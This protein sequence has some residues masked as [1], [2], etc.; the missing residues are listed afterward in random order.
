D[1][2]DPAGGGGPDSPGHRA[3]PGERAAAAPA[4]VGRLPCRPRG[5]LLRRALVG[6]GHG[7]HGTLLLS[8]PE[9]SAKGAAETFADASGSDRSAL[10]LALGSAPQVG[11]EVAPGVRPR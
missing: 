4:A 7:S 5:V 1:R 3:E 11:L 2:G 8:E 9:A 10:N 6:R